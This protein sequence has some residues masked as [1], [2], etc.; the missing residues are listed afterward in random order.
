MRGEKPGCVGTDDNTF[1]IAGC[2]LLAGLEMT[3]M[4]TGNDGAFF[5][6]IA[7]LISMIITARSPKL[8]DSINNIIEKLIR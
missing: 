4:C 3:A 2:T 5:L 6:P 8:Q 7:C 1:S